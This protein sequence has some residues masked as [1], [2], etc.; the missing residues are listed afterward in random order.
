LLSLVS[1][2]VNILILGTIPITMFLGFTTGLLGLINF[3]LSVIPGFF[4][5]WLLWYQL[6][7][8]HIGSSISFGIFTLPKFGIVFVVIVYTAIFIGLYNFKKS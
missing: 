3:Y 7:V 4:T 1:L 8:V 5:Y 2:P 6:K